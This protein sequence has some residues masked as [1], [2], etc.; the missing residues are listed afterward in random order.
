MNIAE[1]LVAP[2]PPF[3]K[4]I[5]NVGLVLTA[6]SAAV[7]GLPVA[8]PVVITQIASYLAVAGSVMTGVSQAT[9]NNEEGESFQY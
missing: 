1:R 2:T 4:K 3:F 7:F 8:L 9:V 6:I 5:R